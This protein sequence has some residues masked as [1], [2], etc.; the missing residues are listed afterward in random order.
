MVNNKKRD[1]FKRLANNRVEKI[2][3]MIRLVGNLSNKNN[4]E[5]SKNDVDKIFTHLNKELRS[6][7]NKFENE[8]G[9]DSKFRI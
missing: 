7:K 5:Y 3:N 2:S 1:D 9:K 6:A 4:Y 8:L